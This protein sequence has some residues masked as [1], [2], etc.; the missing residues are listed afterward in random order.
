[1]RMKLGWSEKAR[2]M[3]TFTISV[4]GALEDR[5]ESRKIAQSFS[6]ANSFDSSIIDGRESHWDRKMAASKSKVRRVR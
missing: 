3:T 5:I 1:M 6:S 4:T 2:T